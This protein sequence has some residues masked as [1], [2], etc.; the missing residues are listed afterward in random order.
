MP[1]ASVCGMLTNLLLSESRERADMRRSQRQTSPNEDPD[2]RPA[3]ET[4][5]REK[6]KQSSRLRLILDAHASVAFL[7]GSVLDLKSGIAFE[8]VQKGRVGSP[9]WRADDSTE[10]G[11]PT[12]EMSETKHGGGPEIAVVISIAQSAQAAARAY[13][14]ASLPQVGKTIMFELPSGP[15]QQGV[16]GGGHA[17]ALAEAISNYLRKSRGYDPSTIAHIFA[18]APNAILFYL[19]QQHQAVAPCIVYEFDF[20]RRGN[21]SYHPSMMID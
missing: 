20:D 17:A 8:L 1:R 13:C 19:G 10:R 15:S 11:A 9:V 5:L 4:F 18:A 14:G 3:V 7:A 16:R 6:V 12:F 21:K 2:I